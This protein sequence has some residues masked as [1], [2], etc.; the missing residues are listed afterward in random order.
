MQCETIFPG[1]YG[2]VL[3]TMAIGKLRS[4]SIKIIQ[5]DVVTTNPTLPRVATS[6]SILSENGKSCMRRALAEGERRWRGCTSED[7]MHPDE[8]G[9]FTSVTY[10]ERDML[11]LLL[12]IRIVNSGLLDKD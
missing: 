4:G 7:P 11:C 3:K 12:D 6:V 10:T 8:N 9:I 5:Q 1:A 2:F